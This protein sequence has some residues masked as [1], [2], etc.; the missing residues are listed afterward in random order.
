M[1]TVGCGVYTSTANRERISNKSRLG[2]WS[3]ETCG[4]GEDTGASLSEIA[5][6]GIFDAT[7]RWA[8]DYALTPDKAL[9]ALGKI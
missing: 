6:G 9:K 1:S 7:G 3:Y 4:I 2:H 5:A 8:L